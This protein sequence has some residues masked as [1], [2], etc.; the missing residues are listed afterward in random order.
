MMDVIYVNIL[1]INKYV[2]NVQLHLIFNYNHLIFKIVKHVHIY[3]VYVNMYHIIQIGFIMLQ[4][5]NI[6]I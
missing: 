3:V 5:I 6:I 2:H 4:E 1:M